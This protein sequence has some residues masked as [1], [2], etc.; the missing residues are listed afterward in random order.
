MRKLLLT[1]ISA[2]FTIIAFAQTEIK[3][4]APN[5]VAAD[6]QFNVTFVI[7]GE[8]APSDFQWIPGSDFQVLWGPQS[9]RSTSLQIING[10]RTKSVQSTYTYVLRPKASG[11][12]V[13]SSATAKVKGKEIKSAPYT[14]QV[15]AAGAASSSSSAAQSSSANNGTGSSASSRAVADQVSDIFLKLDLSRNKVVVGE[16]IIATL[17]LYQRVNVAGFETVRGQP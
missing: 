11:R 2:L 10:K 9:G 16:P 5:V 13:V 1:I 17:K 7:E 3:V 14:I 8:N 4:E 15:A 6:E 12:F